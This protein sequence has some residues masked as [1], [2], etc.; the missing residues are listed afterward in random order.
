MPPKKYLAGDPDGRAAAGGRASKG[1][2]KRS[3]EQK[4]AD[5]QMARL[6]ESVPQMPEDFEPPSAM[7]I[8]NIARVFAPAA[9]H[10]ASDVLAKEASSLPDK[11]NA[12]NL[13]LRHG[14]P[15]SA[16]EQEEIKKLQS[17]VGDLRKEHMQV[18]REMAE[19]TTHLRKEND[20]LIEQ[21]DEAR[22]KIRTT[23]ADVLKVATG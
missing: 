20:A 7:T 19:E 22:S 11:F 5:A 6:L 15:A 9:L 23:P 1:K 21:L 10:F 13:L 8:Q 18:V 14:L 2:P 3:K 4:A 12:A 16:A 17:I